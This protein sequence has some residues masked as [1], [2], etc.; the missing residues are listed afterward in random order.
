M[1][2]LLIGESKLKIVMNKEEMKKHKLDGDSEGLSGGFRRAFWRVLDLAK[3]EVGFDPAGDKILIQFYPT[4]SLGC[5]IFVTKL[6]I[7]PESS[8]RLVCRSDK[9]S[10][11]QKK[12][13]L[14]AFS[15]AISLVGALRAVANA[16]AEPPRSDIYDGGE[17]GYF[18]SI[19]EY[20]KG[21]ESGEFVQI[22]EFGKSLGE[23]FLIYIGEHCTRLTAGD[24]VEQYQKIF[25]S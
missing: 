3:E 25:S 20:S 16:S 15:D 24:A 10:M 18:L 11:L 22:S 19:E 23:D 9:V 14:Y 17:L 4:K 8:A 6:G 5:E 1:E 21:A 13:S 7:L 2:F 12:S